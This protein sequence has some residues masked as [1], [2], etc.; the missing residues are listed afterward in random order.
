MVKKQKYQKQK[1]KQYQVVNIKIGDTTTKRK[2]RKTK[3]KSGSGGAG[4]SITG[5]NTTSIV[6]NN[7]VYP[8]TFNPQEERLM[9]RQE[10]FNTMNNLQGV[11]ISNPVAQQLSNHELTNYRIGK[12][13]PNYY[14][15]DITQRINEPLP[16]KTKS[17]FDRIKG[18]LGS[19]Y[20]VVKDS[21]KIMGVAGLATLGGMAAK[22]L[23]GG[24][25][26]GEVAQN[27]T[28]G[29]INSR[30]SGGGSSPRTAPVIAEGKPKTNRY[31]QLIEAGYSPQD[32][33]RYGGETF[34]NLPTPRQE[35]II[36]GDIRDSM[37]QIAQSQNRPDLAR[38]IQ[39]GSQ[40]LQRQG[41]M[42]FQTPSIRQPVAPPQESNLPAFRPVP[43]IQGFQQF[44]DN[45]RQGLSQLPQDSQL[46]GSIWEMGKPQEDIQAKK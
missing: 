31:D 23:A 43:R 6:N 14:D 26:A 33:E 44:L 28:A 17:V 12:P 37:T 42:D 32:I 2:K 24:G 9:K 29:L 30:L 40:T 39:R 10:L 35:A 11:P 41:I 5:T 20:G 15:R 13:N 36:Q 46:R 8:N 4:S 16:N 38:A 22:H 1:Q 21:A 45:T 19:S 7:N 27:A 18:G 3:S 34:V 25:T